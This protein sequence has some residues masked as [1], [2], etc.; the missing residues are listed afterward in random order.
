MNENKK[1]YPLWLK[2]LVPP[3]LDRSDAFENVLLNYIKTTFIASNIVGLFLWWLILTDSS[4][5]MSVENG[6]SHRN[7]S[8]LFFVGFFVF[9]GLKHQLRSIQAMYQALPIRET[10]KFVLALTVLLILANSLSFNAETNS[11]LV[12]PVY[13]YVTMMPM[14]GILLSTLLLY[15]FFSMEYGPEALLLIVG[16]IGVY[17]YL[18]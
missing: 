7:L 5:L 12:V 3:L 4:F 14:I 6:A 9:I 18:F 16:G 15:D 1:K 13:A 2:L 17:Q 11:V 8:I 10:L